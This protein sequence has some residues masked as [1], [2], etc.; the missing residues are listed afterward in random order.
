MY[1]DRAYI[2]SAVPEP[3]TIIIWSLLGTVALALGWWR[4]RKAA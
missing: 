2:T 4:K 3:S 1:V